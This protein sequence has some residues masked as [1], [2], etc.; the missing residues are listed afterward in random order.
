MN[1]HRVLIR[2]LL[3]YRHAFM[4]RVAADAYLGRWSLLTS[5]RSLELFPASQLVVMV[6]EAFV[7]AVLRACNFS[8]G[9]F[10]LFAY[11][12][13]CGELS[14]SSKTARLRLDEFS[15][16]RMSLMNLLVRS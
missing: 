12:K 15:A 7:H 16:S 6:P 11:L 5:P 14:A 13:C 3:M 8:Y 10:P 9:F 2:R 4:P 1:A